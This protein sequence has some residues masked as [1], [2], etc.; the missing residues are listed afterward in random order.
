LAASL[1]WP[2]IMNGFNISDGY[3]VLLL[4]GGTCGLVLGFGITGVRRVRG[5]LGDP[6]AMR[7][8]KVHALQARLFAGPGDSGVG[9]RAN[10]LLQTR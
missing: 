2:A 9:V 10:S 4:T 3:H 6:D 1:Q 8:T 7:Q 5:I